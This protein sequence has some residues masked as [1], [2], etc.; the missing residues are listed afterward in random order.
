MFKTIIRLVGRV[1]VSSPGD[2]GSFVCRVILETKKL[3]A[4]LPNT[5][6]YVVCINSKVKQYMERIAPFP[7]PRYS[8]N[9]KKTLRIT[10]DYGHQHYFFTLYIY[11]YIHPTNENFC[12]NV[13][14]IQ[15][16][17]IGF[18]SFPRVLVLCEMQLVSS[19][20][21]TRVTVSIFY[22]DNHYTTDTF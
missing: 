4:S 10:L 21:W 18:I 13:Q 1:F 19:R 7:A 16:G 14:N 20:I 9:W 5:Q 3:D 22:D 12:F 2:R 15:I 6:H 11:I 8:S 17:I